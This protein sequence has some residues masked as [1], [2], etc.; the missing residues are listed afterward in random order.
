MDKAPF[1]TVTIPVF[2]AVYSAQV[3]T[4]DDTGAPNTMATLQGI[5]TTTITV[6]GSVRASNSS[7]NARFRYLVI[8]I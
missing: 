4:F 8:G 5:T 2:T 6:Y 7:T 1:G 3:T